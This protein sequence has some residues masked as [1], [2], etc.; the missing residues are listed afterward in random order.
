MSAFGCLFVWL[1][2]CG[3]LW[4]FVL[5]VSL[6]DCFCLV[7]LFA[8]VLVCLVCAVALCVWLAFG[9]LCQFVSVM[10]CLVISA[11]VY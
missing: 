1:L 3:C 4:L 9:F 7:V 5:I 10:A 6:G 11:F 8:W 2:V